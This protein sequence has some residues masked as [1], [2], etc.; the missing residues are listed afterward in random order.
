[1][2][3]PGRRSLEFRTGRGAFPTLAPGELLLEQI[4]GEQLAR[5][6]SRQQ[7]I[8]LWQTQQFAELE[9]QRTLHRARILEALR[10]IPGITVDLQGWCR[11]IK[12]RYALSP[13][14]CLGSLRQSGRFNFGRDIDEFRFSPFPA[15]YLAESPETALHEMFG[16]TA[17]KG[18]LGPQALALTREHSVALL[19][20][21]GQV[22]QVFDLTQPGT[23]QPFV[24]I[25]KTFRFSREYRALERTLGI[26]PASI[27][28]TVSM[29][30]RSFMDPSWR[31]FNSSVDL[32][33]NTQ[34]FGQLAAASGF[35]G[36]LYRSIRTQGRSLVV[37]PRNFAGTSSVVR[38]LDPPEGAR[39]VE[40]T[41][42]TYAEI[43]F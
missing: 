10:S 4:S 40:L 35:E 1:M 9:T 36:I 30:L 34:V 31:V 15:L 41:S 22:N 20:L 12:L 33:A 11:A 18:V 5:S 29:M 25:T 8:L 6:R 23:L 16:A 26:R 32:P 2:K 27:V 17:E 42:R 3:R 21:R 13:L 43:E 39:C 19:S 7:A 38:V 24:D 14:S 28:N 37:F